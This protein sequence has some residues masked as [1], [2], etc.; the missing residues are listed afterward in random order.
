MDQIIRN[1]QKYPMRAFTNASDE[2]PGIKIYLFSIYQLKRLLTLK[3][4]KLIYFSCVKIW[5]VSQQLE[6]WLI[7][8]EWKRVPLI[9]NYL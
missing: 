4:T 6:L 8:I 3:T 5:L 1:Q 7:S 9:E 2:L